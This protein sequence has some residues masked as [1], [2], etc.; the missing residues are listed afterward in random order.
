MAEPASSLPLDLSHEEL[1]TLLGLP[2]HQ[3]LLLPLTVLQA[4]LPLGQR[5]HDEAQTQGVITTAR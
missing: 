2:Q 5:A 1:V 4:L 3:L